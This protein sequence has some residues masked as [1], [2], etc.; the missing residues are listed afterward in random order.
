MKGRQAARI[1]AGLAGELE[2][3]LLAAGCAVPPR[4][5]LAAALWPFALRMA[6]S[7]RA[8]RQAE[9]LHRSA[10]ELAGTSEAQCADA[11]AAIAAAWARAHP[12]RPRHPVTGSRVVDFDPAEWT[13]AL[14]PAASP[15]GE[16]A[17]REVA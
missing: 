2:A 15:A 9:A 5:D 1:A 3:A 11:M 8:L 4:E 6:R 7:R 13:L 12:P 16:R 10:L 17:S 14:R